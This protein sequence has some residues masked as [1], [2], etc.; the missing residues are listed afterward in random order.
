MMILSAMA[1]ISIFNNVG[2][3]DMYSGRILACTQA[4]SRSRHTFYKLLFISFMFV[5]GVK[6]LR[7]V[8]NIV[9]QILHTDY[10]VITK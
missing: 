9:N 2:I 10:V 3:S 6:I 7:S 5:A 8:L 4:H 1:E